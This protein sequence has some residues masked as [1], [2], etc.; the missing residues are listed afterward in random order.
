MEIGIIVVILSV[1]YK[2]AHITHSRRQNLV[3]NVF[4]MT[5]IMAVIA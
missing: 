3:L 1:I 4:I 2:L 5:V